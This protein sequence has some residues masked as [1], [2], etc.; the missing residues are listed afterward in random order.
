LV[1]D[2][3][4]ADD[5]YI[6]L[7]MTYCKEERMPGRS[8]DAGKDTVLTV[9]MPRD[10]HGKLVE[11]AAG[12][13]VSEEIR[14]RLEASL[15]PAFSLPEDPWFH[16]VLHAITHAAAG[17]IE[18]KRKPVL[19]PGLME[20]EEGK[21]RRTHRL[22][23]DVD[24]LGADTTAYEVFV[25]AVHTLL[26]AFAPEGIIAVSRET[27]LRLA[28]QLVALGL[29]SL[30]ERGLAAYANLAEIDRESMRHSGGDAQRLAAEAEK[31]ME[32]ET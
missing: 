15:S 10:L 22:P 11:A 13:S 21:R 9:R 26:K 30:G 4:G 31:R 32:D 8:K 24:R 29:G 12:R 17:A 6:S 19:P 16:D 14:R 1:L 18:L 25:E 20:R 7:C 27:G 28:D 23:Y 3:S 5:Y 2:A